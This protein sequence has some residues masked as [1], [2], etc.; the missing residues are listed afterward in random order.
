ME[1]GAAVAQVTV[2]HLVTGSNPV[3]PAKLSCFLD[4]QERPSET[5][6]GECSR[7]QDCL[8]RKRNGLNLQGVKNKG[9]CPERQ[10]G[11]TVNLLAMPS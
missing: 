1:C 2:N 6:K 8:P 10:R 11:E 9:E 4:K 5:N 3:T 7:M